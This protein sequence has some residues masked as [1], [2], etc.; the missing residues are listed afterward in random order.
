M[1]WGLTPSWALRPRP[2]VLLAYLCGVVV[3]VS[4]T[5]TVDRSLSK[6]VVTTLLGVS[7]FLGCVWMARGGLADDPRRGALSVA[8]GWLGALFFGVA[9]V[10]GSYLFIR[11]PKTILTLSPTGIT[12]VRVSEDEIPW[13]GVLEVA[14]W[15]VRSGSNP[16]FVV[17]MLRPQ[18]EAQLGLTRVAARTR[19][20]NSRVGAD[21]LSILVSDL[22]ARPSF[23]IEVI[24]AYADAHSQLS[25][26]V[27]D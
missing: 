15:Q 21:G 14:V 7:F 26:S 12:D 5:L 9:L 2:P 20:F 18:V 11:R 1:G 3:D 13:S 22:K 25:G 8:L 19:K 17:L 10:M 6:Q 4:K 27:T 23:L 16:T 24:T